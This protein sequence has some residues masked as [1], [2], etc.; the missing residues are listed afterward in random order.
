VA[1]LDD[2]SAKNEAKEAVSL[3]TPMG[4][5]HLRTQQNYTVEFVCLFGRV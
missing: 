2:H 1:Q 5:L 3:E 4:V